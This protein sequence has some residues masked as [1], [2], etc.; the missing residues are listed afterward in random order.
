MCWH[1]PTVNLAVNK[2]FWNYFL[3]TLF[4]FHFLHSLAMIFCNH[5]PYPD[6]NSLTFIHILI[7]KTHMKSFTAKIMGLSG[8]N[9][10]IDFIIFKVLKKIYPF[11]FSKLD[12]ISL[13]K[14]FPKTLKK[15]PYNLSISLFV[16][17]FQLWLKRI[18]QCGTLS[19][20]NDRREH[21]GYENTLL[22]ISSDKFQFTEKWG[23][24]EVHSNIKSLLGYLK[25]FWFLKKGAGMWPWAWW[26]IV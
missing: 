6:T 18:A 23:L 8:C 24:S 17:N 10:N 7:W 12:C 19:E 14:I 16:V 15:R 9:Q 25:Q 26:H 20:G 2:I 5:W 3:I 21:W 1:L 11:F 13:K 4:S 22:Q